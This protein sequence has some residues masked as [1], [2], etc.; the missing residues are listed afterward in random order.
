MTERL[1]VTVDDAAAALAISRRT[2]YQLL[3]NGALESVHIGTARRIPTE[4]L[5]A[6]V[7]RLR[8]AS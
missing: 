1:L 6:Y 8:E 2:V 3:D 4:A 5:V 7:Q